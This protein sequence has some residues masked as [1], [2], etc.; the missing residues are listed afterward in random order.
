M[1]AL[2]LPGLFFFGVIVLV[3]LAQTANVHTKAQTETQQSFWGFIGSALTGRATVHAITKA[4]RAALS[5]WALAN[6]KPVAAWFAALNVLIR[7]VFRVQSQTVEQTADAI[8]RL[9]GHTIPTAAKKA[10]APAQAK[11]NAAAKTAHAALGTATATRTSLHGYKVSTA[12]KIAHATRAVD[13]T[14]PGQIADVSRRE[15]VITKDVGALRGRTK[16]LED[17]ALD[18]W[19]W[20]RSHPLS[21]VTG[22]FAGAVAVALARLGFGFLRCRSWQRV[23]RSLTCSMADDLGALLGIAATAAVISDFRDLV[24]IAQEVEHETASAIHVLLDL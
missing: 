7:D 8:E 19:G 23:G 11:A 3:A 18:T 12:P 22:A 13:V 5:R 1:A 21:G 16:A 2:L 4:T 10:A 17:G 24:K 9:R 6:M 20:L 15:G 14:L